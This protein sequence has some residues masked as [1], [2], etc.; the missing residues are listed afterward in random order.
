MNVRVFRRQSKHSRRT[1]TIFLTERLYASTK[2][3]S[4]F[5]VRTMDDYSHFPPLNLFKRVLKAFPECALL[6]ACLW[7][8]KPKCNHISVRRKEV[9]NHFL[10]SPTI[11]RNYLIELNRLDLLSFDETSEFFVIS[12]I[13][14][15]D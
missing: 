2:K 4:T 10:I 7:A 15:N 14:L 9:K 3:K 1:K 13:A 5:F 8:L 6:Y 11:F 12:F